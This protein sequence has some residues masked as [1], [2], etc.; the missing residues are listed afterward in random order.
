MPEPTD[1]PPAGGAGLCC[2]CG[3]ERHFAL[4]REPRACANC[5][6][7]L[8][9]DCGD[10]AGAVEAAF[11]TAAR[12][13]DAEP[14]AAVLDPPLAVPPPPPL[15]VPDCQACGGFGRVHEDRTD[16]N[17]P[18]YADFAPIDR[19][20]IAAGAPH[21]WRVVPCRWCKGLAREPAADEVILT[22]LEF[23]ALPEYS[24]TVPHPVEI[25]LQW[26]GTDNAN[27]PVPLWQMGRPTWRTVKRHPQW[28]RGAYVESPESP[29]CASIEWKRIT[30]HDDPVRVGD[31]CPTCNGFGQVGQRPRTPGLIGCFLE[32]CGDCAGT[33]QVPRSLAERLAALRDTKPLEPDAEDADAEDD[34]A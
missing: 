1:R 25:G 34:E 10:R 20:R 31:V 28:W 27:L 9:D 2:W 12:H 26:R 33:G 21:P 19:D 8:C 3:Q 11:C 23:E 7:W 14:V 24:A 17:Q 6:R 4:S 13:P 30:I 16:R 29:R 15:S 32:R 22:T 5:R 18:V